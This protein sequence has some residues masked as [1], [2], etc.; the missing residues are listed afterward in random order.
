MESD[1]LEKELGGEEVEGSE[2]VAV[3]LQLVQAP[4]KHPLVVAGHQSQ[5]AVARCVSVADTACSRC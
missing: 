2:G 3:A 4:Q 5:V 1:L